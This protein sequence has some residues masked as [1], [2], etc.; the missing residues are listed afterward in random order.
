MGR[1][2][3]EETEE[4]SAALMSL[5]EKMMVKQYKFG[6]LYS[7]GDQRTDEDMLNNGMH[8]LLRVGG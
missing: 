8:Q 4:F 6:V 3:P 7:H 2:R 1:V 5:E